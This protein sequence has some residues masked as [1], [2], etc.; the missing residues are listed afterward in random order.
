MNKLRILFFLLPIS[1]FAQ[2]PAESIQANCL[3]SYKFFL[4]VD[5]QGN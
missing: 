1:P 5:E 3:K 2:Q 4:S